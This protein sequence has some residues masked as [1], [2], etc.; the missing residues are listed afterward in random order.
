MRFSVHFPQTQLE[1]HTHTH[2]HATNTHRTLALNT[3]THTRIAFSWAG[4]YANCP[5]KWL[6][7]LHFCCGFPSFTFGPRVFCVF[8]N[9]L[10]LCSRL[11][12]VSNTRHLF[13]S[14]FFPFFVDK[15]LLGFLSHLISTCCTLLHCYT[16][17]A[18]GFSHYLRVFRSAFR[19]NLGKLIRGWLFVTR[20]MT[21]WSDSVCAKFHVVG[22]PSLLAR[23]AGKSQVQVFSC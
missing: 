19:L 23:S 16:L 17:S 2:A 15:S 22:V 13:L 5:Q 4:K 14:F 20:K 11:F 3:L 7:T 1:I 6:Q 9:N 18:G 10:T 12:S 21:V 8:S